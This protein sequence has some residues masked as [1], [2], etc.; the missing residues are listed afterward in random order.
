MSFD[1][2]KII[3]YNKGTAKV[4]A[5]S[6]RRRIKN[7]TWWTTC[8]LPPDEESIR[9]PALKSRSHR[10]KD[11]RPSTFWI[12][13]CYRQKKDK[14]KSHTR[15]RREWNSTAEEFLSPPVFRAGFFYFG[16]LLFVV[17]CWDLVHRIANPTI[18]PEPPVLKGS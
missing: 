8:I 4:K 13:N 1:F 10:M 18:S 15:N 12:F 5:G 17:G 6:A 14:I 3:V 11:E 7:A 2:F 9:A 16:C